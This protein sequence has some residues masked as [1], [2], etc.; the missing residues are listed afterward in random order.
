[1]Y[2]EAKKFC[3]EKWKYPK[4]FS[5]EWEF[6]IAG[7]NLWDKES[8]FDMFPFFAE[9]LEELKSCES[10]LTFQQLQKTLSLLENV[11]TGDFL[12]ATFMRGVRQVKRDCLGEY[13]PG[14]P[15]LLGV[16]KGPEDM[17][18]ILNQLWINKLE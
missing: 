11:F 18:N 12:T 3:E 14:F 9:A 2:D 13:F 10:L 7:A 1:M 8:I 6:G 17:I 5:F 15:V 4:V 16:K